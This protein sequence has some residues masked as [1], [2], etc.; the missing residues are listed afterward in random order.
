MQ[1]KDYTAEAFALDTDF[2]QWVQQPTPARDQFWQQWLLEHPEQ[3]AEV[4][5]ARHLILLANFREHQPNAEEKEEVWN[6]IVETRSS[7]KVR[8]LE[9]PQKRQ[10]W[11]AW[12]A[13]VAALISICTV[14]FLVQFNNPVR[15]T[16]GFGES[17]QVLLEDGSSVL[18]NANSSLEVLPYWGLGPSRKVRLEGEAFFKVV[19]NKGAGDKKFTVHTKELDVQ[20]LGTQFNVFSRPRK[21]QVV[22]NTGKVKL[23]LKQSTGIQ[24]IMMK[25]GELVELDASERT[26]LILEVNPALYNDWT[27]QEWILDNTTFG[28]VAAK[29]QETFGIEISFANPDIAQERMTGV[30]STANLNELLDALATINKLEIQ[31]NGERVVFT[32]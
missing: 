26:P 23:A 20:V 14:F 2:Q 9:P 21:T 18:L 5:R 10:V 13:A 6:R 12:A 11:Y 15:Y 4:E 17:R 19:K 16:T 32:R 8:K 22:L 3:S 27:R 7:A 30:V 31:R 25:P 29:L 24:T 1:Y 28:A